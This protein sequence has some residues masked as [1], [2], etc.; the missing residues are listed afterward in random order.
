VNKRHVKLVVVLPVGPDNEGGDTIDSILL[1][2]TPDVRI[3]AIDDSKKSATRR[4]LET[5]DE[6]V[7]VLQPAGQGMRGGLWTS[8]AN[9][10]A[11]I[12]ER[13]AFDTLLRIDTDALVI[14]FNPEEDAR[15]FFKEHPET[16]M[17]GSYKLDCNG[18]RR[19]FEVVCAR[20]R[21]EY[22]IRGLWNMRRRRVLRAWM[23]RA[24]RFNYEPGEH[25]LGAAV[26]MSAACIAA[27][28]EGGYLQTDVF[29]ESLIS[30]DQLFSLVTIACGYELSDFATGDLPMGLRWR[31]LPDSPENLVRRQKKIVHSV[32]YWQDM[33]QDAIRQYFAKARHHDRETCE[34]GQRLA[35]VAIDDDMP[36]RSPSA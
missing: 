1:Y 22:G 26:F 19:D 9:A 14:G 13:Y 28:Y 33:N 30:E 31:G 27:M 16:G 12:F 3:F 34:E 6:R 17:L 23:K 5:V 8:V 11:H 32:K 29:K 18:E 36:R 4:F 24:S 2:A 7:T 20:L 21:T 10:Y 25:I 15:R 35:V